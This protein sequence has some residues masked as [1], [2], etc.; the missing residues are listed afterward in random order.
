[1]DVPHGVQNENGMQAASAWNKTI[2]RVFLKNGFKSCGADHC[3]YVKRS[4][5]GY[6]YVC[7]YVDGMI[8]AVKTVGEILKEA[9]K[10][11]FK[12]KELGT[13]K[14]I[15]GMEIDHDKN[16]ETNMIKQPRYIDDVVKQLG[17]LQSKA[18]DNP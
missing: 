18:T 4:N 13:A 15:L 8:I 14:V 10:N 9:L 12:I 3:V 16:D 1:M 11:A 7:L 17:Q 2:Y 6:V 5:I